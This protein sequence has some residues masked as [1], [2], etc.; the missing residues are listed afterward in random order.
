MD[1][2]V[3]QESRSQPVLVVLILTRKYLITCVLCVYVL[4]STYTLNEAISMI[5]IVKPH[6]WR[7][8]SVHQKH[9]LYFILA[10]YLW[11][12]DDSLT[13][14]DS[15]AGWKC[16]VHR[17]NSW[18]FWLISLRDYLVHLICKL[19]K[20]WQQ[21]PHFLLTHTSWLCICKF[22][23]GHYRNCPHTI[24]FIQICNIFRTIIWLLLT[25]LFLM[26]SLSVYILVEVFFI[27]Y[28]RLQNMWN[29]L[30]CCVAYLNSLI[31]KFIC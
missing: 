18:S 13:K 27:P 2:K 20:N 30:S 6:T 29:F 1:S 24:L 4:Y 15:T 5:D 22:M 16:L 21:R 26:I 11:R 28:T 19:A 23:A 8:L 3:W 17:F 14:A 12:L 7:L 25:E 9:V 10:Y 31:N